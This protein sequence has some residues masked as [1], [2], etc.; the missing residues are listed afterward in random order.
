MSSGVFVGPFDRAAARAHGL[1][2]VGAKLTGAARHRDVPCFEDAGAAA[3]VDFVDA[4][5]P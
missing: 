4:A 1:N 2:V 5:L 3:V